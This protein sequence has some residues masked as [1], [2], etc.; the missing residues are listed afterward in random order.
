RELRGLGGR[1]HRQAV[2]LGHQ[3]VWVAVPTNGLRERVAA[4]RSASR[5][6]G[7]ALLPEPRVWLFLRHVSSQSARV[8]R[9]RGGRPLLRP[10]GCN[11]A[12]SSPAPRACA[13]P[14]PP[15]RR[16]TPRPE[17]S[18]AVCS[19]RSRCLEQFERSE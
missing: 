15:R 4:P 16:E 19:I 8:L 11:T 1:L 13:G 12:G 17:G 2:D 10:Y 9:S 6:T 7:L 18:R 14:Q 3:L 5:V